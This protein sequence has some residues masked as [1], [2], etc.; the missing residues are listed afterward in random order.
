[1]STNFL[2]NHKIEVEAAIKEIENYDVDKYT[3]KKPVF[4]YYIRIKGKEYS[5][6][7]T[8][9]KEALR[10]A[11]KIYGKYSLKNFYCIFTKIKKVE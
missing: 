2:E 4:S 7:T 3:R 6:D 8:N 5:L 10:I 11:T 1:M 9:E